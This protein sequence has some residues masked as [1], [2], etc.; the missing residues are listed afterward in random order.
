MSPGPRDGDE[1]MITEGIG[2]SPRSPCS[3]HLSANRAGACLERGREQCQRDSGLEVKV[4][5]CPSF[6]FG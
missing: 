3:V 4:F 6:E 1:R 5:S 2:P